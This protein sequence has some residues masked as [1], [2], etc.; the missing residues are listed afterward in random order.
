MGGIKPPADYF[1]RQLVKAKRRTIVLC[2]ISASIGYIVCHI[3]GVY[4][5]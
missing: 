5:V 4:N 2:V 1:Y 3:I